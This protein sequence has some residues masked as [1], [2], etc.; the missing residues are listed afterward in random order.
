[1]DDLHSIY[2]ERLSTHSVALKTARQAVKDSSAAHNREAVAAIRRIAHSL[3][4]SGATYG[5][6]EITD[7]ALLL[8]KSDDESLITQLNKL[9]RVIEKTIASSKEQ[10]SVI[11]I[12]EEDDAISRQLTTKLASPNREIIVAKT[13]TKAL[14]I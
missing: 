6:P 14:Q 4:G 12:V 3:K 10:K 5:F 2:L 1:M 13:S 11:L 7:A 9:L 8:E